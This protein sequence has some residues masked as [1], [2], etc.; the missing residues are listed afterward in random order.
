MINFKQ[1]VPNFCSGFEPLYYEFKD[2][3]DMIT[4]DFC[5][6]YTSDPNFH[7]FSQALPKD[8]EEYTDQRIKLMAEFNEGLNWW[9]LGFIDAGTVVQIPVW[10]PRYKK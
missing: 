7:R 3:H 8:S 10:E 5:K 2:E 4:S 9:V 6:R 1:H